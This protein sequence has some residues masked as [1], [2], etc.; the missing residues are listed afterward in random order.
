MV[1]TQ[2]KQ[3]NS[4]EDLEAKNAKMQEESKKFNDKMN[5]SSQQ[6]QKLKQ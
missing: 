5:Q 1:K 3:E 6:I 2:S 4:I